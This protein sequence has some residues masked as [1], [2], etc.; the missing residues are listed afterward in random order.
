MDWITDNPNFNKVSGVLQVDLINN[1]PL[2]TE[3]Y[4]YA[5]KYRYAAYR[6]TKYIL[7]KDDISKLDSYFSSIAYLYRHSIELDCQQ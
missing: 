4:E 6:I 5:Q 7:E 3:F 1:K 2:E